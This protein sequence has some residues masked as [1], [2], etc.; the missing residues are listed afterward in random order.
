MPLAPFGPLLESVRG[1]TWPARR[2]AGGALPGV[3]VSRLR[4]AAPELSE[5]RLYRQGDDPRQLDWKLLARS[6]RAYI[7]LAEDRAILATWFVIDASASMAWPPPHHD[8]WQRACALAIA[9][10]SIALAA[11]DPVGLIA[12]HGSGVVRIPARARRGA[13]RA[14]AATLREV[15]PAGSP[16]LAPALAGVRPGARVVL[17]SDFL[18]DERDALRAARGLSAAGSDVHAVHIVA[19]EEL[20]PPRR[21]ARATDPEDPAIAR[22]LD[23]DS[24]EGY[25]ARFAEWRESTAHEWR[26]AG[27]DWTEVSTADDPVRAVRR[28][29]GAGAAP[30]PSVLT[31]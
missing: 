8:K 3:H 15:A 19:R 28:I 5:Y 10:A 26:R 17:L 14:M 21:V 2:R 30:A 11:G 24:R 1:L 25:L 16:P 22:P 13:V 6:D 4:G 9:L 29:V 27:A 23:D 20:D 31:A 7:R 18:G 12:V